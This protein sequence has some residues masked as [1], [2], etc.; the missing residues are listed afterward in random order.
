MKHICYFLFVLK[1]YWHSSR[2]SIPFIY[3]V[4][5]IIIK[6]YIKVFSIR[7]QIIHDEIICCIAEP[8]FETS[9]SPRRN[10][11]D[12]YDGSTKASSSDIRSQRLVRRNRLGDRSGKSVGGMAWF[13]S[14]SGGRHR[15]VARNRMLAENSPLRLRFATSHILPATLSSKF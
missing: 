3:E 8:E 4:N 11:K 5:I 1:V 7:Y 2:N 15:T 12:S 14:D 10:I 9:L 13:L 6:I